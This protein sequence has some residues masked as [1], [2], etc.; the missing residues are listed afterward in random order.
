VCSRSSVHT[1]TS[2]V[3]NGCGRVCR[4]RSAARRPRGPV[5][6]ARSAGNRMASHGFLAPGVGRVSRSRAT[7]VWPGEDAGRLGRDVSRGHVR[8]TER[9]RCEAPGGGR[10]AGYVGP[11]GLGRPV[12]CTWGRTGLPASLC[13]ARRGGAGDALLLAAPSSEAAEAWAAAGQAVNSCADRYSPRASA[14]TSRIALI[15]ASGSAS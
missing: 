9:V 1:A 6:C 8:R 2:R 14:T 7:H 12:P 3:R 15:T 4:L 5:G 10:F 11:H 13:S